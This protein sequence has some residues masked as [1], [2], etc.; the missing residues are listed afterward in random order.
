MPRRAFHLAIS[1]V[2]EAP[3]AV[4]LSNTVT[5]TPEN[6]SDVKVADISITDDALGTNVLSLSGADATSFSIVDGAG[7]KELHFNGGA[8]FEAKAGY[9][10]VVNVNDASVGGNPDASQAFHLAI[11]DVNEAPTA[12][13]LSNAVTSTPENGSDVKVADI[14]ITD[15]ALGTNV[16][17]L[18][19]ADA[20]SFSIV[21]GVGGKELHFNGG[22]NFEAKAGYDV[23]VNVNDA[24][25]GGTPDASQA[26]HLA[27]TDVVEADSD[28]SNDHDTDTATATTADWGETNGIDVKVGNGG[29]NTISGGNGGDTLYG[30]GGNDTLNG[31]NGVDTIYGQAGNDTLNGDN[32]G[33]TLYGGSGDDLLFG[34]G[35]GDQL[36]GGSGNDT[37]VFTAAD[38]S[39]LN[40]PNAPDTIRDF[41]H[42][43]DKIDVTAIDAYTANPNTA[44]DQAFTWGGTTATVHG[45]WYTEGGGN[46]TLHFDTNGTTGSD[47]MTIVLTGTGLGLTAS[48][49]LL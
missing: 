44:G 12:V 23:T 42:G 49:F 39:S 32:D 3:T 5:S 37:F 4:V 46:T 20:A 14:S 13:V 29:D 31:N 21:D 8:N 9:D 45:V 43:F 30:A 34:G 15:D 24:T 33:D 48:D 2:N 19:G 22:A 26:F 11:T 17:S 1:D 38:D 10:V 16:L 25:V 41:H 18:S 28:T 36:W 7:G 47:E 27:I 40:G 6:G 35:G